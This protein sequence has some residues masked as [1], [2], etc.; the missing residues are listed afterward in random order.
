[1]T[2]L[3]C[4]GFQDSAT[5]QKPEWDNSAPWSSFTGRDGAAASA[6][7]FSSNT[8]SRT[9]TLPSAAATCITGTAFYFTSTAPMGQ[10][11]L[12]ILGLVRSGVLELVVTVNATGF[13]ELRRTSPTGTLLGTSSGHA[14]LAITTWRHIALKATLHSSTGSAEVRLD[15]VPMITVSGVST[16]VTTG[17]VTAIR[18]AAG[19]TTAGSGVAFDDL[20]VCD[21]VDGTATDGRA[22]NDFLGD[23]KIA[24]IFP[25][26]DGDLSQ[27]TPSTGTNHSATVDEVPVNTTD[28]NAAA[29]AG[30]RD[31]YQHTDLPA[32]AVAVLAIRG[33][34][35]AQKTDAGAAS[36][37]HLV[38]ENSVVTAG[39]TKALSTTYAG[40]WSE[41]L[42]LKP[43]NGTVFAVS[44][45]NAMQAGVESA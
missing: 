18:M 16:S 28:W 24:S 27:W 36:V 11:N 42:K 44:D 2:F 40:Y 10:S 15:D 5:N 39:S 21:G 13:I 23:V 45:V 6:G 9:Y 25:S 37:K 17:S 33:G 41:I 34:F 26:S 22:N 32:A 38:K 4:D 7:Q 31:L 3:G 12:V 19:G 29:T 43:S 30:L 14:P 1:M 35:Y 8:V 20:Y